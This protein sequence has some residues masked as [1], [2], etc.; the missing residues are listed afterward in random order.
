MKKDGISINSV[1]LSVLVM[2]HFNNIVY[3][4]HNYSSDSDAYSFPC[5]IVLPKGDETRYPLKE[6][7]IVRGNIKIEM[8]TRQFIII[9]NEVDQAPTKE[10]SD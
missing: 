5:K 10:S 1:E 9:A 6:E 8:G 4:Y 7:V 2:K 3:G